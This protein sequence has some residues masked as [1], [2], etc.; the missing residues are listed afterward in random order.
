MIAPEERLA[1]LERAIAD[2]VELAGSMP[3]VVEGRRDVAALRRLGVEG[4]VLTVN[5]G[6]ALI[7]FCDRLAERTTEA[8]LLT[9]W[10]RTGGHILRHLRDN[11]RGRVRMHREVRKAIALYAEVRD[12]ES[13]PTYLESLRRRVAEVTRAPGPDASRA[14]R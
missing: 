8:V 1:N 4:E 9:D 14:E 5:G 6:M 11:L 13:L 7:D 10:D 12:V 2:L 3:V